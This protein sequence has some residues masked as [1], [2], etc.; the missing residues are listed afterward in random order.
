MSGCVYCGRADVPVTEVYDPELGEVS[1]CDNNEC[2]AYV[3]GDDEED[4]S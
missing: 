2:L 3:L 1:V 4:G